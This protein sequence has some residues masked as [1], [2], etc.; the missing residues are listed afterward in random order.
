VTEQALMVYVVFP[1]IMA[2]ITWAC[3]AYYSRNAAR[4]SQKAPAITKATR[5]VEVRDERYFYRIRT[6][7]TRG[8][9]ELIRTVYYRIPNDHLVPMLKL[10]NSARITPASEEYR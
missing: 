6:G 9:E 4:N 8:G 10:L 5:R 7:R 3:M 2:G 1:A